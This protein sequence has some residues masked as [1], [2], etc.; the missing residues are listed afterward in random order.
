VFKEQA[1]TFY[2]DGIRK[3]VDH[4]DIRIEK[5]RDYVEK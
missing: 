2:S 3:L 1:K 5:R 4:Q